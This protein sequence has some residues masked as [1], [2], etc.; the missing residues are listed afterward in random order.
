[1][2]TPPHPNASSSRGTRLWNKTLWTFPKSDHSRNYTRSAVSL[3][4]VS[5][6]WLFVLL[7]I[8]HQTV[9][10]SSMQG[11]VRGCRNHQEASFSRSR[12]ISSAGQAATKPNSVFSEGCFIKQLRVR[13]ML[14]CG[15]GCMHALLHISR[16]SKRLSFLYTT[17]Y[18]L[19][20]FV[21]KGCFLP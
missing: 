9:S 12:C 14:R 13:W 3:L 17:C 5:V 20:L 6:L 7:C 11:Q 8:S 21:F 10:S 16:K 4:V 18:I 15:V 19:C 1:M 2:Y